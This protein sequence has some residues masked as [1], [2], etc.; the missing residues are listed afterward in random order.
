MTGIRHQ[1]IVQLLYV[2]VEI[3]GNVSD[4]EIQVAQW[5]LTYLTLVSWYQTPPPGSDKADNEPNS[6]PV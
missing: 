3:L 1:T 4:T 6:F 2:H 5:L